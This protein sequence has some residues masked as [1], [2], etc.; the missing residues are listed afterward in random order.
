M[1]KVRKSYSHQSKMVIMCVG[2]ECAP[3][4]MIYAIDY[5]SNMS[6]TRKITVGMEYAC[7]CDCASV[8]ERMHMW[9][10]RRINFP[11]ALYFVH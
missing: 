7:E 1:V 4:C 9:L 11:R 2:S 6:G 5:S 8:P 10:N 3:T